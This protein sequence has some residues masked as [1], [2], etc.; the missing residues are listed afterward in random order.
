MEEGLL[1]DDRLADGE[2]IEEEELEIEDADGDKQDREGIQIVEENSLDMIAA[3]IL[4][5]EGKFEERDQLLQQRQNSEEIRI[6]EERETKIN[7]NQTKQQKKSKKKTIKYN[8]DEKGFCKKC[9][10]YR[11]PRAHHCSKCNK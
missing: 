1:R 5:Q 4:E 8:F 2:E 7:E 3:Q 6:Q 11:P 9:S 10:S